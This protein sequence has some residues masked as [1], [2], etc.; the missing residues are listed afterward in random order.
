MMTDIEGE[1]QPGSA[2]DELDK[3]NGQTDDT[4]GGVT[5]ALKDIKYLVEERYYDLLEDPDRPSLDVYSAEY[6]E[7]LIE[8]LGYMSRGILKHL[9]NIG[10]LQNKLKLAAIHARELYR[11]IEGEEKN[12][13][14]MRDVTPEIE[15]QLDALYVEYGKLHFD[16]NEAAGR[17]QFDSAIE[18]DC[19]KMDVGVEINKLRV[20]VKLIQSEDNYEND[21]MVRLSEVLPDEPNT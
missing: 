5:G 13:D 1:D 9:G 8:S 18:L 2:S 16:A 14:A 12:A 10:E 4:I 6:Y 17:K 11:Q 7:E 20:A 15:E 3:L 19:R 21:N